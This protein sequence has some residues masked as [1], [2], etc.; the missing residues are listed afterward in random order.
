ME[1]LYIVSVTLKNR[2]LYLITTKWFASYNVLYTYTVRDA[3]FLAEIIHMKLGRLHVGTSNLINCPLGILVD[4][5]DSVVERDIQKR[6]LIDK[7]EEEVRLLKLKEHDPA[8]WMR[9]IPDGAFD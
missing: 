4:L 1:S 9:G 5:V 6:L 8:D 2:Q 7:I 3:A